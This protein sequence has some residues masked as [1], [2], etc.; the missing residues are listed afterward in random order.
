MPLN[1]IAKEER[2]NDWGKE[3]ME[4]S[5]RR[6]VGKRHGGRNTEGEMGQLLSECLEEKEKRGGEEK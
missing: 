4:K 6:R 1:V 3:A 2:K 5:R